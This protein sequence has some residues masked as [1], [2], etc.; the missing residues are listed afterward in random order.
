MF[1]FACFWLNAC[2]VSFTPW[3]GCFFFVGSWSSGNPAFFFF[4]LSVY[5]KRFLNAFNHRGPPPPGVQLV[6]TFSLTSSS[7]LGS[8]LGIEIKAAQYSPSRTGS[9]RQ[10]ESGVR[11]TLSQKLMVLWVFGGF[12]LKFQV[13]KFQLALHFFGQ[14]LGTT[15]V[16]GGP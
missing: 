2:F 1:L 16:Q 6:S 12:Y 4:F 3:S 9:R 10:H 15:Q 13:I 8:T 11:S 14:V 5:R 7:H